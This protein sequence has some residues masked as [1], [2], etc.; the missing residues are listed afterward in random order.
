MNCYLVRIIGS[1]DLVGILFA[2]DI[3][4]LVLLIDES[5]PIDLRVR[6]TPSRF[7]LLVRTLGRGSD[8][9]ETQRRLT[10]TSMTTT[11]FRGVTYTFGQLVGLAT[12]QAALGSDRSRS[13]TRAKKEEKAG[14][15]K[16]EPQERANYPVSAKG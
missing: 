8:Q 10:M 3:V 9:A 2:W 5:G 16:T 7:A 4:E 13:C 1:R 6:R 12:L 15:K 11:G 14:L